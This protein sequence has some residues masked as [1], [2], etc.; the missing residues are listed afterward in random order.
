MVARSSALSLES[1]VRGPGNKTP[2]PFSPYQNGFGY[3]PRCRS[4]H[5]V[6]EAPRDG[7]GRPLCPRC[8][9]NLRTRP[10]GVRG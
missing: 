9:S 10:R 7:M 3:C 1:R 5:L 4:W 2:S 6:A 8:G